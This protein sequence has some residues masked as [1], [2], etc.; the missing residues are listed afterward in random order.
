MRNKPTI[1]VDI[2]EVLMPHFQSLI[3]W[4]NPKYGTQLTLGHNH[5]SDPRPWGTPDYSEAVKRVHGFFDTPNFLN[6]RPFKEAIGAINTLSKNY[7]MVVVTG[8]DTIIEDVTMGWLD[9]HFGELFAEAH[10]TARYSLDGSSRT[11]TDV[12]VAAGADYLIEDTIQDATQAAKAGI[13]AILF[14][15]YPWNKTNKL[16]EGVIRLKNWQE[17][18]EY[19][20]NESAR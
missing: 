11:K 8:R 7:K 3:D 15:N 1:A 4:Y 16:P 9:K 19:F 6:S 10:F 2:D 18:L 17:V 5:P 12:C 14:G 20:E 13:K